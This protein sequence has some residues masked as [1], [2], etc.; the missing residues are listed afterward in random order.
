MKFS[1]TFGQA[2]ES[3]PVF[4]RLTLKG[5]AAVDRAGLGALRSEPR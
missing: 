5:I 1:Q 2:L 3:R 4:Y